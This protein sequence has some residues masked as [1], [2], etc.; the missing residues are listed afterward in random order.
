MQQINNYIHQQSAWANF[1]WRDKDLIYLLGE[2]RYLQ[3]RL[4]GKIEE[5]GFDLKNEANL[6]NLTLDILK[7]NEIEDEILD[8]EEVRSSLARRLGLEISGLVPSDRHVDGVVEMMLDALQ[9]KDN[10]LTNDRLFGWH[11][12]MFPSGRSGLYKIMVG[13]YRDDSLGAMQVVSGGMGKEQ[14]HY[15]AP[16]ANRME[17]EMTHFLKW[18]N[19]KQ[20]LDPILKAGISHFWFV[21]IHPFDD[22][23]GRI[24]RALT[25]LLL[26]RA[27]GVSQRFYSLSA[28]IRVERKGYYAIL[29]KEQKGDLD[30]TEW[31][32]WF[33]TCLQNALLASNEILADV[34]YR[35]QFWKTHAQQNFNA[36]QTKVM[37]LLLDD[38]FGKL[39]TAKWA[40]M[41][42]CSKD[43]ALRDIQ[44]L[45]KKGI[46]KKEMAGGRSTNYELV[47]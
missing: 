20:S 6:K 43:T 47:R 1:Q 37:N 19:Q 31:L 23:N 15:E 42:K 9:K 5:L 29:E 40:K 35:H 13:E 38:F 11:N 14:V 46:L 7:S 10:S 16:S 18:F 22:G 32:L 25:D 44:D 2:V 34:L 27:D 26:S 24:A 3:G 12:S 21:T 28:Q 8:A 39:T 41:V 33:L 36:R 17:A 30:I 4:L 45:M